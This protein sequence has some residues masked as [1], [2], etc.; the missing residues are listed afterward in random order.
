MTLSQFFRHVY[1]SRRYISPG[2]VTTYWATIHRFQ[3]WHGKPIL[4]SRLSANLLRDFLRDYR[5]KNSNASVNQK[6][7]TLLVLWRWAY[8]WGHCPHA[9]PEPHE[10]PKL[11]VPKRTPTAWTVEEFGRL[12]ES[13]VVAAPIHHKDIVWD[14]RHWRALFLVIYDTGERLEALLK[15][16]RCDLSHTAHLTIRGEHRKGQKRDLVR[17]LHA[18]TMEA[19]EALPPHARLFPWPMC[20]RAIFERVNP[21]LHAAG[22]PVDRRSKFH[23]G[24]RTS[25]TQVAVA[26]GIAAASKH[27]DHSTIQLTVDRYIDPRQLPDHDVA[28]AIER[29][30]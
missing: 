15:T 7:R 13:C 6:R 20:R 11:P 22:L 30:N 18:Q 25:A 17:K 8:R 12:L 3:A 10:I 19:I 28:D 2:T 9:A 23:M 5:A 24:R 4:L 29:P 27:L 14:H 1:P 16:A 26:L 21:I